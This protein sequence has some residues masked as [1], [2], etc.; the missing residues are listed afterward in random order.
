MNGKI[1]VRIRMQ[2]N[3][4]LSGASSKSGKEGWC[5][6]I[7]RRLV[8]ASM[9]V[10][11]FSSAVSRV[12]RISLGEKRLNMSSVDSGSSQNC[13]VS[14]LVHGLSDQMLLRLAYR[15]PVWIVGRNDFVLRKP[16]YAFLEHELRVGGSHSE[17]HLAFV[18]SVCC[19]SSDDVARSGLLYLIAT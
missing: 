10:S 9:R 12:L 13:G 1:R 11:R 7:N 14:R 5:R 2:F 15:C 16:E 3:A 6:R 17:S 18:D 4:S 19:Q 8:I